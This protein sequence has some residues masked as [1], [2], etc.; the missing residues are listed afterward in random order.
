MPSLPARRGATA[1]GTRRER[2]PTFAFCYLLFAI[3]AYGLQIAVVFAAG[4]CIFTHQGCE[5]KKKF[6][7]FAVDMR[8]GASHAPTAAGRT[9][10]L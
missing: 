7:N 2:V 5:L 1:V 3:C 9:I 10:I 4:G 8:F 6:V